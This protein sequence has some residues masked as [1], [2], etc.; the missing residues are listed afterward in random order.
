MRVSDSFLSRPAT[1]RLWN[2]AIVL[3]F[4]C[5]IFYARGMINRADTKHILHLHIPNALT[6]ISI[7]NNKKSECT[8]RQQNYFPYAS[9]I[10]NRAKF[11]E[12]PAPV[13]RPFLLPLRSNSNFNFGRIRHSAAFISR[14]TQKKEKILF[15]FTKPDENLY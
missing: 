13:S 2:P 11:S 10:R 7:A 8:W 6:I 15:K 9:K 5:F 14:Y 3:I 4:M 12:K 1:V